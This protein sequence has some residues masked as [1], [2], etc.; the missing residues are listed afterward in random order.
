VVS[1]PNDPPGETDP[2][3]VLHFTGPVSG[4]HILKDIRLSSVAGTNAGVHL[5][6]IEQRFE[7]V[8]EPGFYGLLSLGLG[9][10]F[11]AVRRRKT[12]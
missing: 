5:S 9:G 4:A 2:F 12:A 6:I 3:D 8:P 7:Q 10:L 1:D 11:V